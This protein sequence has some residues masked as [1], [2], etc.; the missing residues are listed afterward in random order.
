MFKVEL[1]WICLNATL[2]CLSSF[3]PS[4]PPL[5]VYSSAGSIVTVSVLTPSAV[6]KSLGILYVY[7]RNEERG[8]GP[9]GRDGWREG[10]REGGR[11][12]G[13]VSC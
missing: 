6:R 2:P 5:P 7:C 11:K 10:G 3:P 9:G 8:G 1:S 4:L 12:G 13:R